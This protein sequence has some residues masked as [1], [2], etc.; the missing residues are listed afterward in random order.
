[1]K[2]VTIAVTMPSIVFIAVSQFVKVASGAAR[3]RHAY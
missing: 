2:L 1:V 3:L